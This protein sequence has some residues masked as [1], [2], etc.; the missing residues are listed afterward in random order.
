MVPEPHTRSERRPVS[1]THRDFTVLEVLV[2]CAVLALMLGVVLSTIS[3]TSSMTRWASDKIGAF[4]SARAA[5]ELMT[6]VLSQATLNSYWDYQFDSAG[7]PTKYIRKSELHFLVG[8][9]DTGPFA[10]TAGTG[11]AIYFQAPVGQTATPTTLGSLENLLNA[12]GY[13]ISY[14]NED[15][16]PS[17]PFPAAVPKYRYRL[18]QAMQPSENLTV[19]ADTTTSDWT[20]DVANFA[21]PVAEN[22]IYLAAW[23]RKAPSED[24]AG[25]ALSTDYSYDSRDQATASPQPE[26]ANQMPPVVQIT[27]VAIDETSAARLCTGTTPPSAVSD[28]FSGLFTSSDQTTFD[29]DIATLESRM[30]DAGIKYR[31]FTAMV[32]IR[33]SKM[34]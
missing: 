13:Y 7:N 25:T 16:L 2:A 19:Y 6:K 4:Q 17:P 31:I 27:L 23:P 3:Q 26:T 15:A 10:G 18:M 5:F 33:E 24:A 22:V 14:G 28:A 21:V 12:V 29:A 32:P 9:A 1:G 34:Q 20:T 8:A 11:Q 30:G